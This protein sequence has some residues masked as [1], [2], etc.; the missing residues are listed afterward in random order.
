MS[1]YLYVNGV[2][3]CGRDM[4]IDVLHVKL[5]VIL[6]FSVSLIPHI[7]LS[8]DKLP[9]CSGVHSSPLPYFARNHR[10]LHFPGFLFL[11][12]LGRFSQWKSMSGPGSGEE[13]VR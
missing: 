13:G 1:E 2:G 7:H 10:G 9:A 4:Y 11:W 8:S 5:E 6:D 12:L 3:I